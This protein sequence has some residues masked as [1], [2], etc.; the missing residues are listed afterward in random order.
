MAFNTVFKGSTSGSIAS[1]PLDI[2]CEI[3][4]YTL[5]NT[6]ASTLT[7][8]L[9]ISSNE[10]GESVRILEKDKS[11]AV[12]GIVQSEISI[13]VLPKYAILITSND[14]LDYYFTLSEI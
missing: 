13:K 3:K 7:V 1:I 10:T 5:V 14:T 4:S 9:F 11:I 2:P 6:S 8:N 12:G